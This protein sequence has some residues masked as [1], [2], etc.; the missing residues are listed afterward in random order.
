MKKNYYLII[1][2][3]LA[4]YMVN[5]WTVEAAVTKTKQPNSYV[6]YVE[7]YTKEFQPFYEIPVELFSL[8]KEIK[9]N[10]VYFFNSDAYKTGEGLDIVLDIIN[11]TWPPNKTIECG[12]SLDPDVNT[13]LGEATADTDANN[14]SLIIYYDD[15]SP[16][17]T[18][19]CNVEIIRTWYV[20]EDCGGGED[21]YHEQTITVVDTQAPTA[22]NV[23]TNVQCISEIP[24][25]DPL[26]I[27]DEADTCG[28]VTVAFLSES[29]NSGAGSIAS[30]YILTRIYSVTDACGNFIDVSHVITVVDDEDPVI[31]LTGAA[32]M[33][34]E[35]C[36]TYTELGA[37]VSDCET[38]LSVTIGGDTVDMSTP[39]VYTVTYN[40]TD[41]A[42]NA[43]TE[44]TR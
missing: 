23:T 32:T 26:V 37:T 15:N 39:G 24:A 31:T 4:S 42:T 40:V 13:I 21:I 2:L 16:D 34:L 14:C 43:A 33:T 3:L 36:G 12:E 29:N 6:N 19:P 20:I 28:S 18:N 9:N 41:T 1:W 35:S 25:V 17:Y 44:V 27:T 38:G 11:I 7:A 30:P 8:E 22:S 5:F 10:S